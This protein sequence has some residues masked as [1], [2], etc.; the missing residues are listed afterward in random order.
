MSQDPNAWWSKD[1]GRDFNKGMAQGFVDS[2]EAWKRKTPR[3]RRQAVRMI[4]VIFMAEGSILYGIY[5]LV[6]RYAYS[7]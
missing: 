4:A 6:I 7:R 3:E 1:I 5:W 2:R